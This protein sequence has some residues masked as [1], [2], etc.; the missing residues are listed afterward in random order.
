MM[1]RGE[2]SG[3]NLALAERHRLTYLKQ[4]RRPAE[5][6]IAVQQDFML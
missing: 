4:H 6:G 2:A 5:S 1:R 3:I